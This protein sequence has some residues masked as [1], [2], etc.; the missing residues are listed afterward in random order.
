MNDEFRKDYALISKDD[1]QLKAYKSKVNTVVIAGPGSGKTRVLALKAISLLETV[2]E[3]PSGLALISYSR[4][5]VRELKKRLRSYGYTA[6]NR[7]FIGTVHS[8]SLVHVIESYGHLFPEYGISYPIRLIPTDVEQSIYNSVISELKITSKMVSPLEISRHRSLSQV[9]RSGIKIGSSDIVAKAA[10]SYE[11]KLFKTNY[12]DFTS[13]I[14]ISAQMIHEQEFVRNSLRS[15][16]PWLLIDEY[17][18]LGKSLHEMVLELTLS[19]DMKLFAVGDVNQSIY[20]FTGG[21]PDFLEELTKNDEIRTI[22]LSSNYRSNQHIIV[23]SLETLVPLP[24]APVYVSK[25]RTEELPDFTFITC[26]EEMEPQ[27]K[28]VAEKVIPNLR[29]K[30]VPYN[31]MGLLLS[32]NEQVKSMAQVLSRNKI[33]FYISKWQFENSAIVVWLQ[34]CASWCI[35]A[36]YQSFDDIFRAWN[37]FL[38]NH[39]D[40]R[41]YKDPIDLKANLHKV[42]SQSKQKLQLDEWLS[43]LISRLDI[44]NLLDSSEMY[45]NEVENLKLLIEEAKHHNLKGAK[46]ERFACLGSPDNEVTITTRHSAKGLEFEYVVL[47]GMEEEKFPN[48]YSLQSSVLL[49]ESQR[50][51]YVCVSRAKRGCFLVRSQSYTSWQKQRQYAPSR[52]WVALHNKFGSNENTFTSI[53]YR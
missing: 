6:N 18:D 32:S 10:L 8:F 53:N 1:Q 2:I 41:K 3:K 36:N 48:Y 50:L 15:R 21:Y 19:A 38:I 20:G 46:L 7:D 24:P 22:Q 25:L 13:I 49:A 29:A 12:L 37:R 35:D 39:N 43:Y 44:A 51:C 31:E 47:F 26:D 5:T 23:A 28:I 52:F 30:K 34:D 42:L 9:G 11:R 33:P 4:E 27:Y 40:D 14:N 45:P 16:F 17:Q